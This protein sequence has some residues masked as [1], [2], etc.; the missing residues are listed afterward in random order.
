LLLSEADF[1][2][3][4]KDLQTFVSAAAKPRFFLLVTVQS[5]RPSMLGIADSSSV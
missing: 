1:F 5:R 3:D 4:E 2:V